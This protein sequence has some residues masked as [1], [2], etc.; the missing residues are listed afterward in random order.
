M[1]DSGLV[2]KRTGLWVHIMDRG[3]NKKLVHPVALHVEQMQPAYQSRVVKPC[4][5]YSFRVAILR[6]IFALANH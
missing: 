5:N 6:G 2:G 1:E 3:E 4:E